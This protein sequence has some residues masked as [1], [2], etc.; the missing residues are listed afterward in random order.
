M[1]AVVRTALGQ[2]ASREVASQH[3]DAR[4]QGRSKTMTAWAALQAPIIVSQKARLAALREILGWV[5]P[6]GLTIV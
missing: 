6:H 4:N 5:D 3:F 1:H 2:I